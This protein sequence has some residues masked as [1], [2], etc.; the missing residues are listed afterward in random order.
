MKILSIAYSKEDLEQVANNTTQL[1]SEERTQLLRILQ[2]FE[3]LF[4]GNLAGWDTEP[5]DLELNL[6]SKP[7]NCKYYHV[8]RINKE[9]FHKDLQR[10]VKTEVLTP[11]NRVNTVLPY[12]LFLRKNR[13]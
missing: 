7:F 11:V 9:N 8:P 10:S 4:D 2:K 13:L 3:D 6:G 5:I 12:L 1:N